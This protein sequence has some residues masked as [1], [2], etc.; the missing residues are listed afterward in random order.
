MAQRGSGVG[1][2]EATAPEQHLDAAAGACGEAGLVR[3]QDRI[4]SVLDQLEDLAVAVAA[5]H[6]RLLDPVM[7][8]DQG[9]VRR[10]GL[11]QPLVVELDVGPQLGRGV[12]RH[13][14]RPGRDGVAVPP[15]D[16]RPMTRS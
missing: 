11:Q 15:S 5:G 3:L 4:G 1:H 12:D 9:L 7:L 10:V 2:V 13:R 8:A 14:G 16:Q 6:H